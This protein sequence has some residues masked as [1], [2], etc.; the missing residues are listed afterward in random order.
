MKT[1]I[2]LKMFH[3]FHWFMHNIDQYVFNTILIS[4]MYLLGGTTHTDPHLNSNYKFVSPWWAATVIWKTGIA[5]IQRIG[6]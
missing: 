3:V 2:I 1:V 5:S 6:L 4:N